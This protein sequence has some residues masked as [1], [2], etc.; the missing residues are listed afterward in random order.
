MILV[1][2][3]SGVAGK[4]EVLVGILEHLVGILRGIVGIK[5]KIVGKTQ[6]GDVSNG[7]FES[8]NLRTNVYI[9]KN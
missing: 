7:D 5:N 9:R 2:I 6:K 4:Y 8:I 3:L 1:G